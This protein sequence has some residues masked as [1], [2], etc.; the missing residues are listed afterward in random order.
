MW[1]SRKESIAAGRAAR[2]SRTARS[3]SAN[4]TGAKS[5]SIDR[6]RSDRRVTA[7]WR[8]FRRS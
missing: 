6:E 2:W 4:A 5:A 8:A 1:S 3:I 7:P